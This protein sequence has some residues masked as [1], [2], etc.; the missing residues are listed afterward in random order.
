[1]SI[2]AVVYVRAAETVENR[3]FH[4]RQGLFVKRF[5]VFMWQSGGLRVGIIWKN[6]VFPTKMPE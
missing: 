4:V 3:I 2:P 6:I 1:M 5:G